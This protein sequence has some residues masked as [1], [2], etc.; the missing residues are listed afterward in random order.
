MLINNFSAAQFEAF[1]SYIYQ[2]FGIAL[3]KEKKDTLKIKIM[4]QMQNNNITSIDEYYDP[5][6]RKRDKVLYIGFVNEI[7]TN[8]QISLEKMRILNLS[9]FLAI[10]QQLRKQRKFAFGVLLA[11]RVKNLIL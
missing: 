6:V 5:L 7:T 10:I 9:V 4:E 2:N 3:G 8:K 1:R 11:Q